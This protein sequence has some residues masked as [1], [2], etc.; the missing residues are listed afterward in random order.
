LVGLVSDIFVEK[1][2]TQST[3]EFYA[4]FH[5]VKSV[6]GVHIHY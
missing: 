5:K 6:F 4:E 1:F 2:L 3:T